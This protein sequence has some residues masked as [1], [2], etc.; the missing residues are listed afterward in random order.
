MNDKPW[1]DWTLTFLTAEKNIYLAIIFI[2]IASVL[3]GAFFWAIAVNNKAFGLALI[4]LGV[5]EIGIFGYQYF[6]YEIKETEKIASLTQNPAQFIASE[7][8]STQ[9]AVQSFIWVKT[10]YAVLIFLLALAISYSE[11][12]TVKGI[13]MALILHLGL[14]ITVDNFAEDYT[15][16][17][18]Q[19]LQQSN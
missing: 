14:A 16:S 9:I 7:K 18:Y 15:K 19:K 10:T 17:Y 4:F 11:Q 6:S 5:L 2:G 12:P 8:V 3:L 13:L 1:L